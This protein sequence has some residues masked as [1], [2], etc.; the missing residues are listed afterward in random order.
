MTRGRAAPIG[1]DMT[2]ERRGAIGQR[3]GVLLFTSSDSDS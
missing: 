2:V 3:K 1:W